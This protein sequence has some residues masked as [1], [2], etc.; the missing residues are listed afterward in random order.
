MKIWPEDGLHGKSTYKVPGRYRSFLNRSGKEG[1][2]KSGLSF[3]S[4][5]DPDKFFTD[6][7]PGFFCNQD[8]DPGINGKYKNLWTFLYSTKK[9]GMEPIL[10][11]R[12][13][14]YRIIF[15]NK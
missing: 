12:E 11:N 7:V 13:F 2:A 14:L 3:S 9:V 1:G 4:A 15:K 8:P 10:L 6:P 5:A